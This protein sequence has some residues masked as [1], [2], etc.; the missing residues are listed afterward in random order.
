M[1]TS[2]AL[3]QALENRFANY[4]TL[5]FFKA[6][7]KCAQNMPKSGQGCKCSMFKK[8]IITLQLLMS[9]Q[10]YYYTITITTTK[11]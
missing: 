4:Y 8:S 2:V 11:L 1:D 9:L 3:E 7:R 10:H 6:F 5:G